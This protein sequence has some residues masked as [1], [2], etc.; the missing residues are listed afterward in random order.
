M[1]LGRSDHTA[2]LLLDGT[3]LVVGGSTGPC[4]GACQLSDSAE[5]Y[6]PVSRTFSLVPGTL[7]VARALHTAT[8]LGDG[9]VLVAGGSSVG[10][11]CND[12]ASAELYDPAT[13]RFSQ[14]QDMI[15]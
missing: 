4:D 13:R 8:L 5:L 1:A 10:Y 12:L 11:C 2:T 9:T 7:A 14:V 3:V 15:Q 6:N